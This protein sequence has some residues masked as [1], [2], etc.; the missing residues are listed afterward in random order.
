MK[1]DT[2]YTRKRRIGSRRGFT[3]I[4]LTLTIMVLGLLATIGFGN[5]Q[6][7]AERAKRA[8]CVANQRHIHEA[9]ILYGIEQDPGTGNVNASALWASELVQNHAAE[10]PSSSDGTNDDYDLMFVASEISLITCDVRGG[11][12]PYT[13]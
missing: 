12:H 13:P 10:C 9:S 2:A 8:S 3:L 6:R 1:R 11:V 5:V 7:F 4:E